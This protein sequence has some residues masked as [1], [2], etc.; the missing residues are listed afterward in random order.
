ML[1]ALDKTRE[2]VE[3]SEI[4]KALKGQIL[5]YLTTARALTQHDDKLFRLASLCHLYNN[6]NLTEE[7]K[8]V[9]IRNLKTVIA[10]RK[11]IYADFDKKMEGFSL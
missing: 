5:A 4:E 6:T 8:E 3:S 9:N 2:L 1:K 10:Q 11:R 7:E